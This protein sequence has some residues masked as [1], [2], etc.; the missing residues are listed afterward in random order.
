MVVLNVPLF[1]QKKN[2]MLC[3]FVCLQMVVNYYGKN[4]SYN[5]I[6]KLANIDS[7]V[8]TW[9]AQTACVALDLGFK[10]EL[11]TYNLS[12]I[13][14]ADISKFRGEKLIKRLRRQKR[15]IDKLYHPEIEY[16]IE[17]IKKGGK[18]TLKI[19]TKEDLV[20]WLKKGIPPIISIKIG[21]AYG[22]A[23]SKK[24]RKTLD[25]HAIVIYGYDGKN[26]LIRDPSPSKYAL[27]KLSEKLLIYSW[28][29]AKAYT[30]LIYK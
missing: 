15:K 6:V 3:G 28:Y 11:I 26:F 12:N 24:R 25:Q 20:N 4:L 29:R 14:D 13:Y 30:L 1:K 10:T 7:Y 22:E 18:L 27:K 21:P 5:D 23:P 16:D 2:D 9:F 17:M 19:P 8:G